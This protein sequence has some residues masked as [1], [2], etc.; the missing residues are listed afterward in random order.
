MDYPL[1]SNTIGAPIPRVGTA[2]KESFIIKKT[3]FESNHLQVRKGATRSRRY[4]KLNYNN[5]TEAELAI[6]E[7]HYRT[8][9]GTVF[10]F[11]HPITAEVFQ[12]TY[13]KGDLEKSYSSYGVYDMNI[14]L[15]SI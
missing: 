7:T 11:T 4:F 6:L 13:A 10:A 9:I 12:V 8:H 5:I 3:S 15:E 1:P 2:E 14:E